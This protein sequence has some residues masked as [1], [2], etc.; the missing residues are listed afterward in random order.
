MYDVR[1]GQKKKPIA[2]PTRT[3]MF[4]GKNLPM[5]AK[6]SQARNLMRL[7]KQFLELVSIFKKSK[8]SETGRLKN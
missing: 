3:G 1:K 2:T 5:R 4:T 6:E 7:S 8:N